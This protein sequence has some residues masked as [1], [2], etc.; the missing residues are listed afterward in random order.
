MI[1]PP[2]RLGR[3]LAKDRLGVNIM[4]GAT[5][6][7]FLAF[8]SFVVL[9]IVKSRLIVFRYSLPELLLSSRW[10][11]VNHTF[12]F[13]PSILGTFIVTLLSMAIA[14]PV[15]LLTAIYIS[16]YLPKRTG[17]YL[18][19]FIDVLAGIPSVVFGL[20]M[21]LVFVPL[22][23][24]LAQRW[25]GIETTGMCILT[26]AITLSIMVFPIIVSLAVESLQALPR[27]MRET[28]L[29]LGSTR[30]QMVKKVLLKGAGPGIISAILLGF[31]RALGETMAVAMVI[32]SRN[33][34]PDSLFSAGQ[35]LPSLIVSSFGEMMSVPEDQSALV[36]VALVLFLL[37]TVT[38]VSAK[39]VNNRLRKKWRY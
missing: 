32:G 7:V 33:T 12:G 36:F 11:P 16:E 2:D 34:L 39:T 13:F 5:L 3:R 9:L 26:A 4:A 20:C 15:S 18:S 1:I 29:S 27:E 35:T 10:D 17:K 31:G 14:I 19:S 24:E 23:A 6:L 30:W 38:N 21:L 22:V 8:L 37:V 25:F 28:S